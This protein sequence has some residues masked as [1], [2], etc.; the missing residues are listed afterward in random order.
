MSDLLSEL[1]GAEIYLWPLISLMVGFAG[2]AHC[3][4]MCGGLVVSSCN[5][6][7]QNIKYQLGRLSG[8]FIISTVIYF[9]GRSFI[10]EASQSLLKMGSV[11]FGLFF[12]CL[13]LKNLIKSQKFTIFNQRIF[14]RLYRS[15]NPLRNY[16]LG[17]FSILL[18]CHFLY[19]FLFVILLSPSLGITFLS[20]FMFWLGTSPALLASEW[21]LKKVLRPL[22][23]KFPKAIPV[24]LILLGIYSLSIRF[25]T[26]EQGAHCAHHR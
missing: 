15:E 7:K 1:K 20:I 10:Q 8:Y 12:I 21:I 26:I 2:S 22:G 4:G 24:L 18:P 23:Q 11:I 19:S 6:I 9:L 14:G 17:F 16:G 13:G 5:G 3:I 25:P